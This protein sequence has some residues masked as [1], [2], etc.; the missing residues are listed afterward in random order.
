VHFDFVLGQLSWDSWHVHRLSCEHISIVLQE[1]DKR[2]FLFVIE[3]GTDDRGLV[4]I[5]ESEVDSFSFFSWP[6]R[7]LGRGFIRRNCKILF[8]CLVINLCGK[9]YRG[10]SSERR[11]N[12][13][14]EAFNGALEVSAHGD[15]TL[16]TRYFEYHIWVVRD[17]HEFF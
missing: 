17:G 5:R 6:H 15:D 10:P 8:H 12:G 4:L 9:S 14:S 7:G 13:T 3:A 2:A 1:L 16:S 11:Q